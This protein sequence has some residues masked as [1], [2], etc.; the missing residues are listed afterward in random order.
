VARALL[1]RTLLRATRIRAA[2]VHHH[3]A[4]MILHAPIPILRIFSEAKAR[5]FYLDFAGFTLLWE[6]RFE[7]GLPL[8]AYARP[9]IETPR[10]NQAD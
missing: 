3:E 6:H 8:Y 10:R 2:C 1:L 5:E 4:I 7:L 9:G